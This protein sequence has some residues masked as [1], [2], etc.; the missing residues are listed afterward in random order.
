MPN[1]ISIKKF[2]SQP[3][4]LNIVELQFDFPRDQEERLGLLSVTVNPEKLDFSF[5]QNNSITQVLSNPNIESTEQQ[6]SVLNKSVNLANKFDNTSDPI[7]D[8]DDA[9]ANLDVHRSL[10][11]NA[12]AS[13]VLSKIN[14]KNTKTKYGVKYA[15]Q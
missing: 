5:S 4:R 9:R 1:K 11:K 2:K 8:L 13:A 14:T 7:F 15:R 6:N 12:K 10:N 3:K